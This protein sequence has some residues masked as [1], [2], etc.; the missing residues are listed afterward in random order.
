MQEKRQKHIET[1][2]EILVKCSSKMKLALDKD[3]TG[4]YFEV[5]EFIIGKPVYRLNDCIEYLNNTL[6]A[7]G[8][9]VTYCFPRV[10]YVSWLTAPSQ[11]LPAPTPAPKP[12]HPHRA[13]ENEFMKRSK[14]NKNSKLVL[15][16]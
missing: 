15:E 3:L 13:K 5:P 12:A 4:V 2:N 11:M 1:F 6:A 10:L 9:N 16:M 14:P 7:R 8:F